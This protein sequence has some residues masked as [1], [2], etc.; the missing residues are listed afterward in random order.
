MISGHFE[1]ARAGA[2]GSQGSAQALYPGVPRGWGVSGTKGCQV[3]SNDCF[4]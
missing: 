2:W 1:R 3:H 4:H